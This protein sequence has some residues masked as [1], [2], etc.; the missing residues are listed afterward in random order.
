MTDHQ[1]ILVDGNRRK[2]LG[3]L[4]PSSL[5]ELAPL[6]MA[7]GFALAVAGWVDVGLFYY[8]SRFGSAE[9]EF[10]TI[11]QTLDAMPLPTLG[12]ALLA[13]G[14]RARGGRVVWTRGLAAVFA[15]VGLLSLAGLVLFALDIPLA[16]KAMQRAAQQAKNGQAAIVSS[17][18]KRGMAKVIAFSVCYALA[19]GWM[20]VTMWRVR[21]ETAPST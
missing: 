4:S 7:V 1:R 11:A 12:L 19:Y 15:L 3:P 16:L 21:R 20:A 13:L 9:W 2:G 6:L 14:I 8:P 18:L 10:G 17:G 5:A